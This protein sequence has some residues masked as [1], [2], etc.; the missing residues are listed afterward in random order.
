LIDDF[1]ILGIE[2]TND[3]SIIKAAYRKRVKEIHPDICPDDEK[4][5][6]HLLF[7]EI[8]KAYKRLLE[9]KKTIENNVVVNEDRIK[10]IIV[11]KDPAFVYY[12]AG[13]KCFQKVHPSVWIKNSVEESESIQVIRDLITLLPKSYYYFSIVVFEYPNSIWVDDSKEKMETIEKR[14]KQ[15]KDIIESFHKWPNVKHEREKRLNEIIER[16]KELE[17]SE[18]KKFRWPK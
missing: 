11:H 13:I 1:R 10:G 12:K 6:N 9:R 14:T 4:Y 18:G 8:N 16:T 2:Q 3:I 17:E 5:R 7:I 15:Y